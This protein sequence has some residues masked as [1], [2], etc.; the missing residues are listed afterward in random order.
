MFDERCLVIYITSEVVCLEVIESRQ[1]CGIWSRPWM[2]D[3]CD[4][5]STK[6]NPS[7]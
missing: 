5:L 2:H 4:T 6:L 3:G 1:L 7:S